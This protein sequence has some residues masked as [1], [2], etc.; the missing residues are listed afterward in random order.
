M[1]LKEIK[2]PS[3]KKFGIFFA[4]VFFC[5]AF[6]SFYHFFIWLSLLFGLIGISFLI[7]AFYRAKLLNPFNV[8]WMR[9]GLLLGMIISPI[10]LA[11]LF[12]VLFS[13]IAILTRMFG[14]DELR[15]RS[16]KNYSYWIS[17]ESSLGKESFKKQF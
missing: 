13:P 7:L 4:V 11:I 1:I 12:Y 16:K 8:L 9:F 3:D 15:L 5:F 6:F 2:L 17:R 10:V 14:R